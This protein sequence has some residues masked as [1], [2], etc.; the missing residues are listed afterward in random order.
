M[1]KNLT[2]S[3]QLLKQFT[4]EKNSWGVRELAK[5]LEANPTVV[6]RILETMKN[7]GFMVQNPVTKKY[8]LGVI[9][10]ELGTV[11]KAGINLEKLIRPL[12]EEMCRISTES[13]FL[14]TIDGE[15]CVTLMAVE[16]VNRVKA[17]AFEGSRAPLYAGASYRAILAFQDDGF[18]ER[19][20]DKGVVRFTSLTL[21]DKQHYWD[22]IRKVREKGVAIS[23]GEYTPDVIAVA[24]PIKDASGA[25]TASLTVSGP[26]YRFSEERQQEA[27]ALLRQK[28]P[29]IENM[30]FRFNIFLA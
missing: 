2:L 12:L 18:I 8:S 29:E 26:T 20:L 30:L 25:V 13:V 27:I 22:E 14:T 16:P 21:T 3:L 24:V 19:I 1:L 10:L 11:M 9:F 15:E 23:Y 17:S 7:N 28:Q 4:H 6:F 5:E